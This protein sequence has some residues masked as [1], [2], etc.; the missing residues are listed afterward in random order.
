MNTGWED[1]IRQELM[2]EICA[3]DLPKETEEQILN[4][5]HGQMKKRRMKMSIGRKHTGVILAAALVVIGSITAIGA[6]KIAFTSGGHSRDDE[7]Q[8]I[9]ELTAKAE[10]EFG[11]TVRIPENISGKLTFSS[12]IVNYG[13][14]WDDEHNKVGSFPEALVYYKDGQGK[15]FTLT[16]V[17]PL[18]KPAEKNSADMSEIYQG[19]KLTGKVDQY[20][21]LPPEQEPTEEQ[22]QLEAEGKL[23]ISYGSSEAE[24][25]IYTYVSWS[26]GELQ[27]LLST[28]EDA[29]LSEMME[30]AKVV[31][32]S[33]R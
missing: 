1:K 4:H 31:I 29:D 18:E 9:T 17:K 16:L 12:G 22:K 5:V 3:V 7:I 24:N 14:A 20:L 28:F 27:Y 26:E 6:G 23:Y 21:F 13:D 15:G 10:D 32:D 11:E 33:G 19:M 30:W 25:E 8:N 2:A